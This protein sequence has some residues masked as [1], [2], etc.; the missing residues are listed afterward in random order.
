MRHYQPGSGGHT[1]ATRALAHACGKHHRMCAGPTKSKG[2]GVRAYVHMHVHLYVHM[3][4]PARISGSYLKHTHLLMRVG[5]TSECVQD[6]Q[7]AKKSNKPL[8]KRGKVVDTVS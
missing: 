7:R 5:D 2:I 1:V 4:E 6:L 3:I 8:R